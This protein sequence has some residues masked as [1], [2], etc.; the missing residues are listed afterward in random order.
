MTER[1]TAASTGIQGALLPFSQAAGK[2]PAL[3]GL[4]MEVR[5]SVRWKK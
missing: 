4:G 5:A 2:L 3:D 1:G